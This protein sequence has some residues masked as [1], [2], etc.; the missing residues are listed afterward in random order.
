M[1]FFYLLHLT[2]GRSTLIIDAASSGGSCNPSAL[3]GR[4]LPLAGWL[5]VEEAGVEAAD[6]KVAVEAAEVLQV[7]PG[8]QKLFFV[9]ITT[10]V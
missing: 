4:G 5:S 8:G 7:H 1:I 6:I 9:I 10:A 2:L 3:V